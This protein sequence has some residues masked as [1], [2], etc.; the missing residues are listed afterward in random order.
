MWDIDEQPTH[1]ALVEFKKA[2]LATNTVLR[3]LKEELIQVPDCYFSRNLEGANEI[4]AQLPGEKLNNKNN[5][6]V[7]CPQC[8]QRSASQKRISPHDLKLT[9][10][11][12][13]CN[14]E[15]KKTDE[16]E[17]KKLDREEEYKLKE[18]TP[19]HLQ[20][21]TPALIF[22]KIRD[23]MARV[24][25]VNLMDILPTSK[26]IG[27]RNVDDIDAIKLIVALEVSFNI[28]IPHKDAIHM[29]TVK[30]AVNYIGQKLAL[31]N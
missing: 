17:A 3:E 21:Q 16:Q 12:E 13:N 22:E 28:E 4:I 18:E 8:G 24:L 15:L 27:Y 11:C 7:S 20:Q 31:I 9:L 23:L 14:F 6:I 2:I 10:I 5:L 25:Q 29:R 1:K 26:C 19:K 30:D